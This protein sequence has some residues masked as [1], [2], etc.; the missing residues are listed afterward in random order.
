MLEEIAEQIRVC[1]KCVLAQSRTN[2]VPGEGSAEAQIMFIGEAPGKAEDSQGRPFV[3]PAGRLLNELL[4][5][6][7]LR[8]PDIFI[9]NIVKCRPPQN[10]DPQPDEVRACRP[11][12][13]GQI[14]ALNPQV[15][16]LLGRPATQTL[17]D[18]K[19]AISKVHAQGF[20][21]EGILYVP[22]YH[23]AAALHN[24][25]LRPTLIEDFTQLRHLLQQRL[26][27]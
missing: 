11:Y 22:L 23:P 21:R 26:G 10:R 19:A 20:E 3:G 6:A 9:T 16:C 27:G 7:G 13:D 24:D 2:A 18:P 12:L 1:T 14:A 15:I 17:L 5:E 25:R 8:R 4:L